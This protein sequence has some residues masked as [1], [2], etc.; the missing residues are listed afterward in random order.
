MSLGACT[1]K[2]RNW[3]TVETFTVDLWSAR[4]GGLGTTRP[5]EHKMYLDLAERSADPVRP[6]RLDRRHRTPRPP[7][8]A[9]GEGLGH[10]SVRERVKGAA[11]RGLGTSVQRLR[12]EDGREL[13]GGAVRVWA[14]PVRACRGGDTAGS[15]R[16]RL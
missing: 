9:R 15:V 12:R 1:G 16:A 7:V 10:E 14:Q 3:P 11:L 4:A 6:L 8:D 2:E 5:V 13:G